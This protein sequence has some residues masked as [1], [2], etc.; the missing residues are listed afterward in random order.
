MFIRCHVVV[1][2]Y[3]AP[4]VLL[5][6]PSFTAATICFNAY[7]CNQFNMFSDGNEAH[8]YVAKRQRLEQAN[9]LMLT[10]RSEMVRASLLNAL[11]TRNHMFINQALHEIT[12]FSPY[13]KPLVIPHHPQRRPHVVSE[14]QLN[15]Y[16]QNHRHSAPRQGLIFPEFN[17]P[18]YQSRRAFDLDAGIAASE[19]Q[20]YHRPRATPTEL[21]FPAKQEVPNSF[22]LADNVAKDLKENGT[23]FNPL[24]Q[25]DENIKDAKELVCVLIDREKGVYQIYKKDDELMKYIKDTGSLGN[26]QFKDINTNKHVNL[27][28]VFTLPSDV[29]IK[30]YPKEEQ[31]SEEVVARKNSR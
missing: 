2:M 28:D 25:E 7:S 26:G 1:P 8:A 21:T 16:R 17:A 19:A 4:L 9:F 12:Y 13:S 14:H 22:H 5:Q 3:Q 23:Y 24:T 18:H 20:S 30:K 10:L 27:K 6:K 29:L 15:Y 31:Q 11:V